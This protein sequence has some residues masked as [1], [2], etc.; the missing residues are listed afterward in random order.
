MASRQPTFSSDELLADAGTDKE[1][2]VQVNI[3]LSNISTFD[4]INAVWD[5]WIVPGTAPGCATVESRLALPDI[6]VEI[7]VLA[8]LPDLD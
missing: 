6:K 4:E 8:V 1:H 2:L 5:Q 3:W 7:Q